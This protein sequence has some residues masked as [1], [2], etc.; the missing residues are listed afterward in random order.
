[1]E[2]VVYKF[3]EKIIYVLKIDQVFASFSK[4]LFEELFPLLFLL[5]YWEEIEIIKEYLTSTAPLRLI[6]NKFNEAVCNARRI[7]QLWPIHPHKKYEN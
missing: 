3:P 2:I 4:I 7:F 5:P 1:M 6:K